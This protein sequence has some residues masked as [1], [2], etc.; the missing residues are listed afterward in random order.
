MF[1]D[2]S[3]VG[4]RLI[5]VH[6]R[7][8]QVELKVPQLEEGARELMLQHSHI[9]RQTT[10]IFHLPGEVVHLLVLLSCHVEQLG[11]LVEVADT[12]L[13]K[14][15]EAVVCEGAQDALSRLV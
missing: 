5:P 14:S 6:V 11:A 9:H 3:Q 15:N 7:E 8:L 12:V 4:Q 13:T 1:F 10:I 2:Q